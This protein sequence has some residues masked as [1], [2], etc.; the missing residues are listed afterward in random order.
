[1]RCWI[2]WALWGGVVEEDDRDE[3]WMIGMS[4]KGKGKQE[5]DLGIRGK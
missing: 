5:K 2:W 3:R 1:M 4:G